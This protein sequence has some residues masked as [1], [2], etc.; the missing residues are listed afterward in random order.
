[1]LYVYIEN[2]KFKKQ[3]AYVFDT[4]FQILGI[5]V[6]YAEE[7]CFS[8]MKDKDFLI[9]Y[10]DEEGTF[11]KYADIDMNKIFILNSGKLFC[12]FY[13]SE[14]SLPKDIKKF[15]LEYPIKGEKNIVSLYHKDSKLFINRD[16]IQGKL[17]ISTNIDVI[18]DIF[19]MLTRYEEFINKNEKNKEKYCRFPAEV[20]AAYRYGFLQRPI[21]NE[22]IELIWSL[23]QETNSGYHRKVWWG[24]KE[25]AACLTH[26]IDEIKMYTNVFKVAKHEAALLI[27][28]KDSKRA[29]TYMKNYVEVLK[30]YKQDPFWTFEYLINTELKYDFRSSFYFMSGGT[31]KYDGKYNAEDKRLFNMVY[32]LNKLGFET[33]YHGSFYSYDNLAK[34]KEEIKSLERSNEFNGYGCRQHFLRFSVPITWE[35]QEKNGLLYDTTLGFAEAEGFRSGICFPYRPFDLI[36]NRVLDI[37][38]IPLIVMDAALKDEKYR[39]LNYKEGE[40]AIINMINTVKRYNGVFTLL[41]HNTS[42]ANEWKNWIK[43]YEDTIKYLY[44]SNA[45]GASGREIICI[46]DKEV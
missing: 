21:V 11:D 19:F 26:D 14:S 44:E 36:Q 16:N 38:E 23:I 3:I 43:V 37:W 39:H 41:W 31:S 40:D 10:I 35:I 12:D 9:L 1:V 42:F 20:S 22:Y 28:Y 7:V 32:R 46:L 24:N 25:F 29:L 34:M 33:A 13:L 30:D 18:S 2:K 5:Q 8:Y 27:K 45:L 15:E 4:I 17:L 6:S